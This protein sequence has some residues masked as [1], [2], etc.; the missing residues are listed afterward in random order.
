MPS[1]R[2]G[3]RKPTQRSKRSSQR[4]RT[5]ARTGR[6]EVETTSIQ[7]QSRTGTGKGPNR[8]LRMSG[9]IPA[10]VYGQGEDN[11]SISVKP[12][13]VVDVL[14]SSFGVNAV[15][16]LQVDGG[17][18][19][20]VLIRD[21]QMHPVR[22]TLLHVD[23]LRV[24]PEKPVVVKVPIAIDGRSHAEKMGGKRRIVTPRIAVRCLPA[25]IPESIHYD[26]SDIERT[27]V[28]YITELTMPEGVEAVY[29]RSVPIVSIT[30]V[31]ASAEGDGEDGADG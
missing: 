23:F 6:S 9:M 22:R 30:A 12:R 31:K 1:R 27:T 3:V 11:L 28:I 24:S 7:V 25:N 10:V 2:R 4:G 14:R 20:L 15:L 29:R 19:P 18:G 5:S 17:A 13:S 8:Q 21:F 16:Q 26:V